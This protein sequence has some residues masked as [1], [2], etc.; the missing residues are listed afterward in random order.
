MQRLFSV[1]TRRFHKGEE[2]EYEENKNLQVMN[3]FKVHLE[4]QTFENVSLKIAMPDMWKEKHVEVISQT[5]T[6]SLE[7]GKDLAVHF[8]VKFPGEITASTGE[9][10]I[11][12]IFLD[13]K[14]N[15]IKLEKDLILV[16]PKSL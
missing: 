9:Q 11:K 12:L 1:C 5:D 15:Q 2:E 7:A 14:K 16:R 3:H 6:I 4:N 13:L 10:S 8:F